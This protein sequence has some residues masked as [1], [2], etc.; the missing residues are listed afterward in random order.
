MLF[1]ISWHHILRLG[2]QRYFRLPK[3]PSDNGLLDGLI[4]RC[5]DFEAHFKLNSVFQKCIPPLNIYIILCILVLGNAEH[6][7]CD[8]VEFFSPPVAPRPHAG[9]GLLIH[10][11][12]RSHATTHHG[13]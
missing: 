2:A 8:N 12:S 3:H 10:E 11:V 1:R 13:Q 9:Q 4:L 7:Y 6:F 5:T